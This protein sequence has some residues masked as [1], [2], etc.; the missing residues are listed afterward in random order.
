MREA[1]KQKAV[2]EWMKQKPEACRQK[3]CGHTA[4]DGPGYDDCGKLIS[5]L[6]CG[7]RVYDPCF[8]CLYD[9]SQPEW[10]DILDTVLQLMRE[11][12]K[13][14]CPRHHRIM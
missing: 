10:L 14:T 13:T 1:G 5:C 9:I 12:L 2:E 6:I 7:K 8:L 3:T 4:I 11:K